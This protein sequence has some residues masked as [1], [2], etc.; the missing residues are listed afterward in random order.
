MLQR[1]I[2]IKKAKDSRIESFLTIQ[3][4][5]CFKKLITP[6]FSINSKRVYQLEK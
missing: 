1:R 6:Y 4:F 5:H 3:Y 2:A